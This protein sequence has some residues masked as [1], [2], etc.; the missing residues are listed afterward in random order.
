MKFIDEYHR[1]F[2]NEKLQMSE[3]KDNYTKCLLYLLALNPD[4]RNHFNEIFDIKEREVNR[5][6]I[7]KAWQTSGSENVTRLAFN[8][9]NGAINDS[10]KDKNMS[11]DYSVTN[12]FC[13]SYAPYFYEAIKL[14]YPEYT[15]ENLVEQ[16]EQE[17]MEY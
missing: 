4:T 8:L 7:N 16:E 12:L 3:I 5:D 15:R 9:W 11:T 1:N 6:S 17:D 14:K 10:G 13:C 2:Y